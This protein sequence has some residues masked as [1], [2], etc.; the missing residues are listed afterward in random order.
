MPYNRELCA[1]F[2]F[3]WWRLLWPGKQCPAA[4]CLKYRRKDHIL[5]T[6]SICKDMV[7]GVVLD[8]LLA[9]VHKMTRRQF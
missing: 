7:H 9:I 4:R 8:A 2:G 1:F 5:K 3:R 6:T